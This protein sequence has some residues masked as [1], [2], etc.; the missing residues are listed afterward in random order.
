MPPYQQA[1]KTVAPL[2]QL[3][4]LRLND[5]LFI[6]GMSTVGTCCTLHITGAAAQL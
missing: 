4:L 6:W 1:L 3:F 2:I 5:L